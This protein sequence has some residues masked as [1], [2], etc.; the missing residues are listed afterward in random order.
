MGLYWDRV[1]LIGTTVLLLIPTL[2]LL[3]LSVPSLIVMVLIGRR[4]V[5]NWPVDDRAA[6]YA[7]GYDDATDPGMAGQP[8]AKDQRQAHDPR[9]DQQRTVRFAPR[10]TRSAPAGGQPGR[11]RIH[12]DTTRITPET[13]AATP[14]VGK[15]ALDVAIHYPW[16]DGCRHEQI[17]IEAPTGQITPM[18]E[19]EILKGL[20]QQNPDAE[21]VEIA[22]IIP[23]GQQV[24]AGGGWR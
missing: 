24:P 22:R 16:A 15:F 1:K 6:G 2:W 8:Y 23:L 13:A 14:V 9:V 11:S 5:K 10:S 21:R 12:A 7:E 17:E 20:R 4:L 19:D 3:G 18:W